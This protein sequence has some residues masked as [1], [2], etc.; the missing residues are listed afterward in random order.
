MCRCSRRQVL[1]FAALAPLTLS[2][3]TRQTEGPEE[4]RFGRETCTLCGMIISDKQFAAEIR[5]GPDGAL[6][7][8]DDI[9]DAVNW[10]EKQSWRATDLREFWVMNSENGSDWLDARTAF[11][12]TGAVS[13][14]DY[15][16]AAV[17][18]E[19]PGA[20]SFAT[21]AEGAR[22]RGANFRCLPDEEARDA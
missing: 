16:F 18:T 19:R 11:F 12:L 8:F 21:M 17:A 1:A 13:P 20:V 2:G 14:M 6:V 9:G 5:G 15:G 10:L 22:K 7:K 3:C 4:I